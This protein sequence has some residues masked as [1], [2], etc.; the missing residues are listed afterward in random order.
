[1]ALR[2]YWTSVKLALPLG[3]APRHLWSMVHM[4]AMLVEGGGGAGGE[5]CMCGKKL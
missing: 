2:L 5:G 4:S 3:V 1:M